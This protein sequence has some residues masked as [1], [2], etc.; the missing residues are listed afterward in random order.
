VFTIHKLAY[1]TTGPD[2][3]IPQSGRLSAKT[4]PAF[5]LESTSTVMD[6]T[7]LFGISDPTGL[8][9]YQGFGGGDLAKLQAAVQ[10]VKDRLKKC[11]NCAGS[12]TLKI[13]HNL[14]LATLF[15]MPE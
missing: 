4:Q 14:E 10:Q 2:T 7:I 3:M 12:E 11:D 13:L 9:N 6:R 15:M 8:T 1:S 5:E